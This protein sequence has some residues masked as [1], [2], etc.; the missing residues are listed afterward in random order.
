[1]GGKE[2]TLII[3][4]EAAS[5][6]SAIDKVLP[7]TTHRLCMWHIMRKVPDKV[8]PSLK[9]NDDFYVLLNLC[10]WGSETAT[11]F[12]ETWSALNADFSLKDNIWLAD[13]Y[14]QSV[15]HRCLRTIRMYIWREF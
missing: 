2:P 12:E 1:V 8:E 7:S 14:I 4:D 3:R 13:R 10:V 9:N 6:K 11:K 5:I 15:S